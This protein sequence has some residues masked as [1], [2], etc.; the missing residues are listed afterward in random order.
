MSWITDE[1]IETTNEILSVLTY[2][3]L[4][5]AEDKQAV[6]QAQRLLNEHKDEL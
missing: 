2:E 1:Q 5:D 6:N 4:E 3:H